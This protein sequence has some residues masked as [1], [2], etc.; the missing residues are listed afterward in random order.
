VSRITSTFDALKARQEKAL[1]CYLPVG[2]PSVEATMELVP[3]LAEAGADIVEL[4]LPFSDPLADG[5]TIQRASYAALRNGVNTTTCLEVAASLRRGLDIPLL[6]MGYYNT[7]LSYGPVQVG[8]ACQRAGLDGLIVAD[9]PPEESGELRSICR[10]SGL[11]LVFLLAPN[12]TEE[13]IAKVAAQ[14][15]GFVYCVSVA[16]VTGARQSVSVDLPG[17]LERVRRQT[18]LPTAV[19]FGISRPEHVETVTR[20]SDGAIVG[21]AL[22]DLVD[23]LSPA[24]RRAGVI[25][26]VKQMKGPRPEKADGGNS[27]EVEPEARSGVT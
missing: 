3:A 13:R 14:A 21:S 25:E 2:Y 4:G 27:A 5:A 12:S 24:E 22:I 9:L 11:D 19:G 16:G 17:F 20:W 6:F 8:L 23:G 15:S 7:I 1:I 26:Y 10:S 18:T